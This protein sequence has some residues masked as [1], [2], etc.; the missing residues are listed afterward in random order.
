[1]LVK[2]EAQTPAEI[3]QFAQLAASRMS[4]TLLK[5]A[6]HIEQGRDRDTQASIVR[7]IAKQLQEQMTE[8][9]VS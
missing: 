1:M 4:V 2:D 7:N 6:E 5:A 3:I 9:M 8:W